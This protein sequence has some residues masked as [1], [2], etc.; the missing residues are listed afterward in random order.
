[1][2]L[3][4]LADAYIPDRAIVCHCY[5]F[6]IF[7]NL[8]LLNMTREKKVTNKIKIGYTIKVQKSTEYT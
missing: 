7:A 2:L 6:Y 3:L 4:A 8:F 1:M 5:Y